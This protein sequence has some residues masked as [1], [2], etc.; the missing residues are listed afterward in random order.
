MLRSEPRTLGKR[1]RLGL[2]VGWGGSGRGP[3]WEKGP[4]F[5]LC[6]FTF[7]LPLG[8]ACPS[9]QWVA[10]E[11]L[12]MPRWEMASSSLWVAALAVMA[13]GS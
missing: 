3:N 13:L 9:V 2:R 1:N 12:P 6:A 4:G 5:R 11:P 7:P 10:W 8:S